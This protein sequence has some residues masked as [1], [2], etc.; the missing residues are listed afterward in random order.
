MKINI[1]K[2]EY[3]LLLDILSIASW[4]MNA[5]TIGEDKFP[6][7]EALRKKIYSYFKEM[8]AEDRIE[9]A[10]NLDDYFELSEYEEHIHDTFLSSYEENFFWDELID[11]LAERDVLCSVRIENLHQLEVIDR[12]RLIEDA[13]EKYETEFEKHGLE[14]L[15]IILDSQPSSY[16]QKRDE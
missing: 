3:R 11:R 8:G 15:R 7:H 14:R 10:K 12:I 13:K 2:H 9:F 4:V 1:T 5:F 6:A 16:S